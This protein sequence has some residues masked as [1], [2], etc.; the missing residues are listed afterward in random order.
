MCKMIGP[1]SGP[2]SMTTREVVE[3]PVRVKRKIFDDFHIDNFCHEVCQ[4]GKKRYLTELRN[5]VDAT[6]IET[7]ANPS[8][9]SSSM[10][11]EVANGDGPVTR[12][13]VLV[14][15]GTWDP[16][17][18]GHTEFAD[19]STS[20][21]NHTEIQTLTDVQTVDNDYETIL[22]YWE[23][24]NVSENGQNVANSVEVP[25][26]LPVT[27]PPLPCAPAEDQENVNLSWLLDFKLDSFIEAPEERTT[28]STNRDSQS[29][30]LTF[31]ADRAT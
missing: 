2:S 7:L 18:L 6:A 4:N 23:P 16:A 29:G 13:E 5:P 11:Q 14:V 26:L 22:S 31:R 1:S 21:G 9:F 30:N 24:T 17:T 8:E 25:G 3:N 28:F 27:V 12:L 10:I 20:I 15:D 19:I